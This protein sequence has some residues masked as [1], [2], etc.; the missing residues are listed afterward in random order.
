MSAGCCVKA[1]AQE[2]ETIR[3][4]LAAEEALANSMRWRKPE[5][6]RVQRMEVH[7][8]QLAAACCSTSAKPPKVWPAQSAWTGALRRGSGHE[9]FP[10]F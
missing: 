2:A 1:V 3:R 8:L 9:Q 7:R 5:I 6:E 10:M 4:V